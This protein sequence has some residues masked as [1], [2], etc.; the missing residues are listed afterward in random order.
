[1]LDTI[2]KEQM[3]ISVCIRKHP[4]LQRSKRERMKYLEKLEYFVQKYASEEM[5]PKE[6]LKD[7]KFFF[8]EENRA[9][10]KKKRIHN[11]RAEVLAKHCMFVN[12]SLLQHHRYIIKHHR[13]AEK[14]R[15]TVILR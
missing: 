11:K 7:Y 15:L 6:V 1:M 10:P 8:L 14:H 3:A 12:I 2:E 9:M 5:F 4:V 13:Y